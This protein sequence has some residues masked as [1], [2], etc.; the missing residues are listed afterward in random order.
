LHNVDLV[1][2]EDHVAMAKDAATLKMYAIATAR[3]C[4]NLSADKQHWVGLGIVAHE[5]PMALLSLMV[6][7]AMENITVAEFLFSLLKNLQ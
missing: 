6:S 3:Q 4:S 2:K 5:I 1:V 7:W